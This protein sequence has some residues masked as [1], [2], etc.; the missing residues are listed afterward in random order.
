MDDATIEVKPDSWILPNRKGFSTW[1]YETFGSKHYAQRKKGNNGKISLFPHQRMV[2]DFMQF[3]SPFRGMLLYHGLGVGKTCASIAAA[4]GFLSH[5]KKVVIMLPASLAPNY[6]REILRCAS[7]GNPM[8][9]LWN[10]VELTQEQGESIG[11]DKTVLKK[12]KGQAWLPYLPSVGTQ[13][14]KD[15]PWNNLEESGQQNAMHNLMSII[16]SKYHFVNYN[17][18][19]TKSA[20]K[21]NEA[22]FQ[23]ALI[24]MDEAHNFVSRVTNGG[25]IGTKLYKNLMYAKGAR[26]ILL[27]GTPVIN[28]PFELCTLLNLLRG[29]MK[30]REVTLLKAATKIP[31]VA[32]VESALADLMKYID[33]IS[34]MGEDRKI[35]WTLC[36]SGFTMMD[37]RKVVKKEQWALGEDEVIKAIHAILQ[38]KFKAGKILSLK[39]AYAL[40]S[41]KDD[42]EELFMDQTNPEAPQPKNLDLFTRRIAGIVSYFRTAG[43]ELFPTVLF[44]KVESVPFSNYQFTEYDKVR[45]TERKME[46]RNKRMGFVAPGIFAAKGTVYRAFS[47]MACNFVFPEKIKRRFPKDLR[48]E[49]EKILTKEVDILED[50]KAPVVGVEGP[51]V[52]VAEVKKYEEHL[53]QVMEQ[54]EKG[55]DEILKPEALEERYSPKMARILHHIKTSPGK[56]LVYSQFRSIEGLGVLRLI[57]KQAG[58][59]E[60]RLEKRGGTYHIADADEVLKPE[61]NNKRFIVFDNDRDKI[62]LLLQLYNGEFSDMPKELQQQTQGFT[63]LRGELASVLMITQSGAEGISLKNVRRV[64]I[65]EPFWNM[66]RMDQVIG[67]AV[68]TESHIEL[69]VNEQNVEVYIYNSVLTKEQLKQN[70][71]LMRLD[72]GMTSDAHVLHIAENKDQLINTF[73]KCMKSAALDCLTHATSNKTM[74]NGLQCYA[75]PIPTNSDE[76][77]YHPYIQRDAIS[78]SKLVHNRKVQGKVVRLQNKKYVVVEEYPNK[79]YDY[80]AYKDAGVLVESRML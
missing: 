50:D 21:Y 73:L 52:K 46:N 26:L 9:K 49:L 8:A 75:F 59:V 58:Y 33:H 70:F 22:F 48:K 39:E 27:S 11:L 68:R 40:P 17:G 44:R 69:P 71:T 32:E 15:V 1:M 35:M 19:T 61:Y 66:V 55:A 14:K 53:K 60:L 80:H 25:Q 62:K 36:P 47:R 42:F 38:Q 65:M 29:P 72:D 78:T 10:L 37:D 43:E 6:R 74:T 2:R 24:I 13:L 76:E 57:L 12:Q 56:T 18:L 45:D 20:A 30:V 4:E 3:D 54:L 23:D 64:L 34:V 77:A 51:D 7:I 5:N 63:N 67:R 41:K 79:L 31:T 28:H 16:D